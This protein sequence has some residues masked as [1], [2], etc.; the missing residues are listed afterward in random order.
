MSADSATE[1]SGILLVN[2]PAKM[3]S[4][5]VVAIVRRLFHTRSVGHTGTLDPDA[6][7][8]LT[9]L[10]GRAVKAS[11]F[12]MKHDKCYEAVLKLGYTTDTEDAGGKVLTESD[13]IPDYEAV[14]AVCESFVGKISQIPPMYSALK[15][16]GKKLVDL[17]R[18]G[19]EI[20][21]APR[22]I[23]VYS[24]AL[25]KTEAPDA[26]KLNI[27]CSSGTYIRT[28]CADIGRALGCG[29]VMESL[30]RVSVGNFS[31]ENA[32]T[33][34]Y[35]KTLSD[36]SLSACLLPV[37]TLFSDLPKTELPAFYLRLA[38]NGCEIYLKKIGC[39]LDVGSLV[40][41]YGGGAFIGIGSVGIYPNGE[42]VK[43][44][45]RF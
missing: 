21:R 19:I 33:P 6:T 12:A 5:D 27:K 45:K 18:Q 31:L 24:L 44:I 17:A 35:L 13:S 4:F 14:K 22:E 37:E 28:L 30:N 39:T 41:I 15:V 1:Q 40:R 26:Y 9:V 34:E 29:G 25:E 16:G 11:D 8:L 10:V 7:G 3:T 43:L 36:E 32:Y 38:L 23:T 20:E 42:A 2:K